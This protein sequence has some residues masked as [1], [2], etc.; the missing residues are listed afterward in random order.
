MKIDVKC[1]AKLPDYRTI[2]LRDLAKKLSCFGSEKKNGG[3][4]RSFHEEE[5]GELLAKNMARTVRRQLNGLILLF[6]EKLLH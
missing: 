4:F 6:G 3:K 2:N 1:V 5:I